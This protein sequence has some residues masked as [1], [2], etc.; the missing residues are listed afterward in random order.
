MIEDRAV[1]ALIDAAWKGQWDSPI[2]DEDLAQGVAIVARVLRDDIAMAWINGD[3]STVVQV[4]Q[5]LNRRI[6]SL[7][8]GSPVTG[9]ST[10]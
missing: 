6:Q 10:L 2:T 1:Q 3:I 4:E 9:D 5:F 8:G 7:V